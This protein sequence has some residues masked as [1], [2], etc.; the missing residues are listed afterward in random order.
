MSL[1][2]S[3]SKSKS[4]GL[5]SAIRKQ[6]LQLNLKPVKKVLVK[7]DPFHQNSAVARNFMYYLL[8]PKVIQTNPQCLVRNEVVNDRSESTVDVSLVNGESVLF[9]CQNLTVLDIFQQFN[10]HITPL[11]PKEEVTEVLVTKTDKKKGGKR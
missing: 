9:K 11:A 3:G 7:F 5:V 1:P 8:S 2:F 4:A 10:K 6:T